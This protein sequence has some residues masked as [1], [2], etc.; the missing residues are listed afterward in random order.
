MFKKLLTITLLSVAS[1]TVKAQYIHYDPIP[2]VPEP[3]VPAIPQTNY[4]PPNYPQSNYP[5]TE[6]S[7][8]EILSLFLIEHAVT[9]NQDVTQSYTGANAQIAIYS[10]FGKVNMTIFFVKSNSQSYGEITDLQSNPVEATSTTYRS[11]VSTFNWHFK[12]TYNDDTGT[13]AVSITQVDK[14]DGIYY[15]CEVKSTYLTS[16]YQ[17]HE[18][19]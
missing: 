9:N 15:V 3:E 2:Y 12:N 17:G 16:V 13:A 19:K 1:M 5:S 11:V 18:L 10:K 4:S 8:E 14:P 6:N 7:K